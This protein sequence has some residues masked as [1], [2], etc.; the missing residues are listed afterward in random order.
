MK[1]QIG[2]SCLMIGCNG[3]P[4]GEI[5]LMLKKAL[6]NPKIS[7]DDAGTL[8]HLKEKVRLSQADRALIFSIYRKNKSRRRW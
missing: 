1:N 4:E 8:R 7:A 5:R 2:V 6:S 3:F